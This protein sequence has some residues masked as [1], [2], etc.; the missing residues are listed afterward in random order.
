MVLRCFAETLPYLNV[1]Y[2]CVSFNKNNS[3]HLADL[4]IFNGIENAFRSDVDTDINL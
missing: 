3:V 2:V 1:C 4:H